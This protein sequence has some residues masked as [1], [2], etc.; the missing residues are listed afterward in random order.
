[1]RRHPD[2]AVPCIIPNTFSFGNP[3]DGGPAWADAVFICPWTIYRCYDD[4][5][6][7][8]E[9]YD[10]MGRYMDYLA[11]HKVKDYIRDHPD[12]D[13]PGFTTG[14]FGDWLAL[15]GS[16]RNDGGTPKVPDWHRPL[17]Q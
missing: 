5:D 11:R 1:M 16:G 8:R 4:V 3:D 12:L 13:R 6:V 14:G 7:L 10:C 17:R 15:D 9:N 2:G